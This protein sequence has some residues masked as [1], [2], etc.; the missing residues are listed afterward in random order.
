MPAANEN[1]IVRPSVVRM[2]TGD[3]YHGT[4][5]AEIVNSELKIERRHAGVVRMDDSGLLLTIHNSQLTISL[6][7][8]SRPY[9]RFEPVADNPQ[10][11]MSFHARQQRGDAGADERGEP[12]AIVERQA[13]GVD[14]LSDMHPDADRKDQRTPLPHRLARPVNRNRDDGGL[15]LDRHDEAPLL[16]RQQLAGAA[17]RAFRKDQERVAVLQPLDGS[18]DRGQALIAVPALERHEA[19]QIER[20]HEHRQLAELGFVQNAKAR[21]QLVE[22]AEDHRGLHVAGVIHG[23][24]RGAG[25]GGG[26]GGGGRRGGGARAAGPRGVAVALAAFARAIERFFI[27][28]QRSSA[29]STFSSI[30][31]VTSC[32]TSVI[33]ETTRNFARSRVRFSRRESFLER[34]RNVS[35]F[36]TSTTS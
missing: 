34:A 18:I 9:G 4:R 11:K 22:R 30:A 12:V 17:A 2:S 6:Q 13:G 27:V 26:G 29:R 24:D 8:R 15:G 5:T 32:E 14:R 20:A 23:V 16:E 31:A 7:C 25:G 10:L 36:R 28:K 3:T 21:E 33:S 19:H 35:L 1:P